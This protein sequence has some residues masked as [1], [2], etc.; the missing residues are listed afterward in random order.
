[1]E[2]ES[3]HNK[4]IVKNLLAQINSSLKLI[5]EWNVNIKAPEEY[6][7]SPEGMRTLAATCMLLESI[8]EAVKKVDKLLPDYLQNVAPD[9]PW[10]QIKGMR[11]HIAHGYF[12]IDADV[13]YDA[14]V[15]DVDSLKTAID[16]LLVRL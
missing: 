3:S 13:I 7:V 5:S 14:V 2:S 16:A 10:K 9:I 15:N 12:D 4:Q 8:G 1:M 6:L 11:D